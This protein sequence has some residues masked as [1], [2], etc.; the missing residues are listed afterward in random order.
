R[1]LGAQLADSPGDVARTTDGPLLLNVQTLDQAHSA[2]RDGGLLNAVDG[3]TVVLTGTFGEV[4]V[5]RFAEEVAAH[6]GELLDAPHTGS[7]PAART[8]TLTFFLAGSPSAR[9]AAQIAIG[10]LGSNLH[11]IGDRPG[12][13]Q[14]MKLVNAIGLAFNAAAIC[15]MER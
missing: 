1:E 12:Q 7:Y 5:Q 11:V 9:E 6:R 3:R 10:N 13:G 2:W 8:G 14:V 4:P 15:E